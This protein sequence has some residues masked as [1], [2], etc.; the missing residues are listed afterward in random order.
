MRIDELHDLCSSPN[1]IQ[2]I[3]S[4]GVRWVG[5]VAHWG[6]GGEICMQMMEKSEGG[7]PLGI[8]KCVLESLN[9]ID[10]AEK[11]QKWRALLNTVMSLRVL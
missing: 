3:K 1:V 4:R 8:L 11:R 10:L 9:W 2:V 7:R 6:G 5:H